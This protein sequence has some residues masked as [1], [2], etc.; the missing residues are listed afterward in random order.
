MKKWNKKTIQK[1]DVQK[2]SE[3]YGIDAITAS[4]LLRRGITQGKD[5]LYYLENDKRFLHNPFEFSIPT[6]NFS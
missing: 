5:I 3:K 2:L 1:E 4:I 6:Q